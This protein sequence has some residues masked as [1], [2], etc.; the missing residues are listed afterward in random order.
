[1]SESKWHPNMIVIAPLLSILYETLGEGCGG[2]AHVVVDDHNYNDLSI[3]YVIEC[4]NEPQNNDRLDRY[5][6]LCLMD[7]LREMTEGQRDLCMQFLE[8]TVFD[9]DLSLYLDYSYVT[10]ESF[11]AWY[12]NRYEFK[13]V[14]NNSSST[15][16]PVYS[17]DLPC[18]DEQ[19]TNS[20]IS[21]QEDQWENS[22]LYNNGS[23]LVG[24]SEGYW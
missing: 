7:Y 5:L 6:V 16:V 22:M 11:D 9:P 8:D 12:S 23:G 20:V 13:P 21:A 3:D 17:S 14:E 15:E 18:F 4:C 1:M 24:R 2:L 19:T 10:Q